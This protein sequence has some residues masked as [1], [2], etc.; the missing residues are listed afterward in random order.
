MADLI[1]PINYGTQN[2]AEADAQIARQMSKVAEKEKLFEEYARRDARR[3]KSI[4]FQKTYGSFGID[5]AIE[6]TQDAI[7]RFEKGMYNVLYGKPEEYS[8]QNQ[9]EVSTENPK[10]RKPKSIN[11]FAYFKREGLNNVIDDLIS[12]DY[13]DLINYV[14]S[15]V[16]VNNNFDPKSPPGDDADFI[17]KQIWKIKKLS[18]DIQYIINEEESEVIN[19]NEKLRRL[20]DKI[21]NVSRKFS[22]FKNYISPELTELQNETGVS[23]NSVNLTQIFPQLKTILPSIEDKLGYL[24]QWTDYR[25]IPISEYQKIINTLDKVNVACTIIQNLS[26]PNDLFG[27][28]GNKINQRIQ[29]T[30][31]ELQKKIDI[32]RPIPILRELIKNLAKLNLILKDCLKVI[33]TLKSFT[34]IIL[35]FITIFKK[36]II[37]FKINPTPNLYTW[38]GFTTTVGDEAGKLKEGVGNFENRLLG[39]N[40]I[41]GLISNILSGLM[42]EIEL[43]ISKVRNLIANL[44]ECTN[45]DKEIVEELKN[46]LETTVSV[47]DQI[48]AFLKNKENSDKN[49]PQNKIGEYT[50]QI[51]TEEVTDE[52]FTL[53]RR[54]GVALDKRAQVALTSTPTF[55]SLDSIIIAEVKQLLM[56]KGLIKSYGQVNYTILE[57]QLINEA[58]SY[59]TIDDINME[60]NYDL[61]DDAQIDPPDN[62]NDDV[63]I[64][65]NSFLNKLQGG[66]ALRKRV[67]KARIKNNESLVT[68]MKK[69]DPEGKYTKDIVKK[70]QGET[71]KLKIEELNVEKNKWKAVLVASPTVAGKI[72]AVKKIK[73]IDQEIYKL[74]NS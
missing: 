68:S 40:Y 54:Y 30:L 65:L 66:R 38:L 69:D 5:K 4:E 62:E 73:E 14:L 6:L 56:S 71:N 43:L 70:T 13:C 47:A 67:R 41:L 21:Q 59:L 58:K 26:T 23:V 8:A 15:E 37:F 72:L 24:R 16:K 1:I 74:K 19:Q 51:V 28:L 17:K 7:L 9:D 36:I 63:G 64:G 29:N 12:V 10:K 46:E 25:Q 60:I 3:A 49:S 61:S 57:E 52:S 31:A 55:A 27:L 35:L 50:I 53:R 18:Y 48:N 20:F 44:E 11:I 32:T 42:I 45:I 34:S 2:S 39:I 22:E 33:N